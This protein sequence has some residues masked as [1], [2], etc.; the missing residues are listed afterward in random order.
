MFLMTKM[1]RP[2]GGWISPISITI[3]ITHAEP[4]QVEAGRLAAAAG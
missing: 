2:T 1:L 3:V 4:D